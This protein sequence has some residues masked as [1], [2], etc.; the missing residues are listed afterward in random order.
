MNL[1]RHVHLLCFRGIG[2]PLGTFCEGAFL[3]ALLWPSVQLLFHIQVLQYEVLQTENVALRLVTY[4]R[5]DTRQH[6]QS[7]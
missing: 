2:S 7:T 6:I 4:H 3:D 1:G 5:C